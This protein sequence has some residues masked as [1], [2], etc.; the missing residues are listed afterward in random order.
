MKEYKINEGVLYEESDNIVV[1]NCNNENQVILL[2]EI[3]TKIWKALKE[4]SISEIISILQDE[5]EGESI[6][7]D[8]IEFVE[9]LEKKDVLI[10]LY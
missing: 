2:R 1:I 9:E 8:I 4:K 6:A 3:E 10:R 5:Y 7:D